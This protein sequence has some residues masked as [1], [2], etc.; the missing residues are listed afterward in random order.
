MTKSIQE[1][2]YH[3]QDNEEKLTKDELLFFKNELES[4]KEKIQKSLEITSKEFSYNDT[5]CPK[6][7]CDHASISSS[8]NATSAIL[9]EQNKTL[10]QI[11]RC[12]HKITLSQY[13][14]CA[15][16]EEVIDIERLKVKIFAEHCISCREIIENQ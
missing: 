7:E 8:N 16:C 3:L 6:D 1:S 14:I 15:M 12:L 4:K 2:Y 9:K 11:N 10:N 5:D 13:G